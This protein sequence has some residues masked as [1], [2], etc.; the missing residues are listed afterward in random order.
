MKDGTIS[1]QE[2]KLKLIKIKKP[3]EATRLS[4]NIGPLFLRLCLQYNFYDIRPSDSPFA[5]LYTIYQTKKLFP[6]DMAIIS[7]KKQG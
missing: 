1:I 7:H 4:L 3:G 5:G 6:E 2:A